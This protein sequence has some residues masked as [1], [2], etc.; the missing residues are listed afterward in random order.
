[1]LINKS[2]KVEKGDLATF[3]LVNGD[4]IVG[5]VEDVDQSSV[6]ADYTV[7]NPMTVVPSQKGVGLFPSLMTGKEKTTVILRAQ[8]VM[9][10]ALTTDELKPHYTQMTT[11]I[12]TAPSGII[13]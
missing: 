12:V 1:M 3:K 11:G 9:M 6:G 10:V 13:S 8:H 2:S 7:S 4:E 5:T